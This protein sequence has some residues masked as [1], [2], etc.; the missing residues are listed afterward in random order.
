M[1]SYIAGIPTITGHGRADDLARTLA[2]GSDHPAER[3]LIIDNGAPARD[4]NDGAR[5]SVYRP[6]HNMGVAGS[7]NF[8]MKWAV[9][10]GVDAVVLVNDDIEI[11]PHTTRVLLE[12]LEEAG[13][14]GVSIAGP[15]KLPFTLLAMRVPRAIE[16]I[17]LFD[18]GFYP[19]YFEDD[20]YLWRLQLAG[21]SDLLRVDVVDLGI[22]W[23]THGTTKLEAGP[24]LRRE[25]EEGYERSRKLYEKKWGGAPLH[26]LYGKPYDPSS[27]RWWKKDKR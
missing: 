18:E 4:W 20:D 8:A 1:L 12:A 11:E 27:A 9:N 3:V 7:W 13:E 22:T 5:R 14:T 26:E 15:T 6:G 25:I 10:R 19:A 23:P 16:E 21:Y 24:E 2:F 17:G